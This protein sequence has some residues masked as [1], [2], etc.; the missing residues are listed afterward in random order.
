MKDHVCNVNDVRL[1]STNSP[2][3][4]I[5]CSAV[6]FVRRQI[7][8]VYGIAAERIDFM[9]QSSRKLGIH[10]ELHASAGSIRFVRVSRAAQ[11]MEASRSAGSRSS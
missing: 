3:F 7:K 11:A 4:S 6:Q 8:C 1:N 9:R 10:D 5:V 2:W